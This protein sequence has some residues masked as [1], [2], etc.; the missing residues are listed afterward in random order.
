MAGDIVQIADVAVAAPL[1]K[2]LSYRVPD[3]LRQAITPGLRVR[4]PLGRRSATGYVLS[5]ADG[6]P[7]GLKPVAEILDRDPLFDPAWARFVQKAAAYYRFPPGEAFRTA[8]PAGLSGKGNDVTILTEKIYSAGTEPGEPAGAKQKEVLAAVRSAGELTLSELRL[9]FEAPHPVLNRLVEL[10]FLAVHEAERQRDPFQDQ[11]IADDSDL[12]L[13]PDQQAALEAL[14]AEL[15]E[16]RFAAAL[17]HGVTG[18]GK[19]EVYLRLIASVLAAGRQAL[20]LVPEIS[21]T[22]QLVSRFRARFARDGVTIAVLH[23][24]LSDGERYDAWRSIA[25]GDVSIVIGAR[26]AIFAPLP[27]LGAIV[28]DE[29]HE[30]SYKQ[31]EGF[32]YHAR[33][34]ALLRGQ[35]ESALVL[36]G[37]AT[38]SLPVYKKAKQGDLLYLPLTGRV[39]NRPMPQ[40]EMLDMREEGMVAP[41]SAPLMQALQENFEQG[42]Q[43]LLL[44]NRRGFA[45]YLICA[46]CGFGV[47][48]PN[49]E[50]TLTYHQAAR[51]LL[52]HYCDYDQAPPDTCPRCSGYQ[53][54]PEGSGTERLEEELTA[55]FPDCRIARMDRDTTTAKWAHQ[56]LVE[57]VIAGEVDILVGT[58]MVAKGHDFPNMTLVGVVDADNSLNFPDF[59][60]AERTFSLLVQVAGRAGRGEREGRVLVQ[61]FDPEHYAL[62]AAM[63]H[64]YHD[65]YEQE[66]AFREALGY[67][68][69]GN[70]VNLV[71]SSNDQ[72]KVGRTA[73]SL[74]AELVHYGAGVEVL[75]PAPCPLARLRGRSRS[76]IL[77][78]AEKR[79]PLHRLLQYLNHLDKKIPGGVRLA[80]DVDPIDML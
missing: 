27:N 76:Q 4:V 7:E 28:V 23:S 29:E 70:L 75:G 18:S 2:T 25:R 22:P 8:L 53:L 52:C 67:P 69:F 62:Q 40:V 41:L 47:R 42:G 34:L 78:K 43:S 51:K 33:D 80:V 68:P 50:I 55:A 39:G 31:S 26:S 9:R 73:E 37:S 56:R 77:L 46:D 71:L 1:D 24:G 60:S 45:P 36:L 12:T 58:Q 10:G 65:F 64:D 32:R 20:I 61:T 14:E 3:E 66:I 21:L 13:G 63:Q 54:L 35:D 11:P 72:A 38:P 15:A 30:T 6:S 49:C 17:L 5:L 57:R 48:C 79:M 19:T 59:R 74:A 16:E 44:L